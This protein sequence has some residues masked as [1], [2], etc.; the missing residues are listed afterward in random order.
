MNKGHFLFTTGTH[1]IW[2]REYIS[3]TSHELVLVPLMLYKTVT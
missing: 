2:K 3:F 1:H